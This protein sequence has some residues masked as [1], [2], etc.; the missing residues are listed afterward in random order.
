MRDLIKILTSVQCL[1]FCSF[2]K[3]SLLKSERKFASSQVKHKKGVFGSDEWME[4][5]ILGVIGL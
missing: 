1:I 2:H 4:E 5:I 3:D